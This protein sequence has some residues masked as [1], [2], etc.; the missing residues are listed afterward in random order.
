[1]T[2]KFSVGRWRGVFFVH[3]FRTFSAFR[4][5]L[6]VW[7]NVIC[8]PDVRHDRLEHV[9]LAGLHN[10]ACCVC[11]N[12]VLQI[13]LTRCAEYK[14]RI[15]GLPVVRVLAVELTQITDSLS[16]PVCSPVQD[17]S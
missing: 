15:S 8:F 10:V 3:I 5:L 1:M 11:C 17:S 7:A 4:L 14:T 13:T 2:L 9:N 6:C 12:I 16:I